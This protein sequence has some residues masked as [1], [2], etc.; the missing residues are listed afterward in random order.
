MDWVVHL[1]YGVMIVG[2]I[3]CFVFSKNHLR[4]LRKASNR[5]ALAFVTLSNYISP[6]PPKSGLLLE[7]GDGVKPL[8][9]PRQ[10]E[11]I[12]AILRRAGGTRSVE[13]FAELDAAAEAVAKRAGFNRTHKAQFVDPVDQMLLLTHTFLVGCEDLTR[14]DTPEK[15]AAF[16][17]YLMDQ[18]KH[19]MLLL[20]RI[21]GDMSDAYR[22]LNK[23]YA[24]EMERLEEE[25]MEER[26]RQSKEKAAKKQ[27]AGKKETQK[28]KSKPGDK[29]PENPPAAGERAPGAEA[30]KP[31][32]GENLR[33]KWGGWGCG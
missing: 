25:E 27:G 10:P 32:E 30:G 11:D 18:P 21:T 17:S 2:I 14:I 1:A 13:L 9:A 28:K 20:K 24:R 12:R 15:K 31:P 16:D 22:D 7:A 3:F 23:V 4:D 26:V 29:P 19:R 5:F 33:D 8:P 6:H